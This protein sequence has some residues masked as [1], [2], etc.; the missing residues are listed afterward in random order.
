MLDICLSESLNA[1][2]HKI[3]W[4]NGSSTESISANWRYC[5]DK[6]LLFVESMDFF[7]NFNLSNIW[8]CLKILRMCTITLNATSKRVLTYCV[9][10]IFAPFGPLWWQLTSITY[11]YSFCFPQKKHLYKTL[12]GQ[13][14]WF[15][16]KIGFSLHVSFGQMAPTSLIS[17]KTRIEWCFFL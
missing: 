8:R 15:V 13:S 17:C 6:T 1:W 12:W 4:E 5:I 7:H 2:G 9:P 3:C 10:P 11:L 14:R 16:G